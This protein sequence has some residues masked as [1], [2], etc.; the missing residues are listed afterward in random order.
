MK[1]ALIIIDIQNDYFENGTMTLV[2]SDKASENA[3]LL[4]DRFRADSLPIIH[5]QHIATRPTATFFL[6]N[7]KG[8]EIQDN[9]KPLGQEKVIV[10][11]YPNS[12]RET[13]LLDYLKGKNI[14]D[15]VICGMMTHMCVDATARAAKDFGFNIV[16]IGDACA[17]KDQEINGQIV[18]AEEIQKSFLAALN[19]FYTTIKTTQ[20]YLEKK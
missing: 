19:Y 3:K 7:T 18:K 9:V 20:Q 17:T 2:G 11:H 12:F 13:E 1:T 5:I 8:A 4:L 16:L 10:K 14:T 15:L 6:P